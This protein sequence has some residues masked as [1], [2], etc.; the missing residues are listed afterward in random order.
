[1]VSISE[2]LD[3]FGFENMLLIAVFLISFTLINFALKKAFTRQFKEPSTAVTSVIAFAV[4]LIIVYGV[5]AMEIDL[6]SFFFDIG[7]DSA[8]LEMLVYFVLL[9]GIAFIFYKFGFAKTLMITGI[10]LIIVS[11][12]DWF[13]EADTILFAGIA[14]FVVAFI[15]FLVQRR[16]KGESIGSS[17]ASSSR[18]D[19]A[20]RERERRYRDR[21]EEERREKTLR[22]EREMEREQRF[23]AQ[24]AEDNARRAAQEAQ[25]QGTPEAQEAA[26][27]AKEKAR[28]EDKMWEDARAQ[29]AQRTRELAAKAKQQAKWDEMIRKDAE[30]RKRETEEKQR[31]YDLQIQLKKNAE[32]RAAE[33]EAY[34]EKERKEKEKLRKRKADLEW[35]IGERRQ[36]V[37]DTNAFLNN[38]NAPNRSEDNIRTAKNNLNKISNELK[39]FENEL[40]FINRRL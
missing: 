40:D 29:D 11:F 15:I 30:E 24:R 25:R 14:I 21:I 9:A 18:I 5:S 7:I 33:Y 34:A 37:A 26:R 32:I 38:Y 8:I 31:A 4:S 27:R 2:I 13:Y 35:S 20:Q 39:N 1:M 10:L 36:W 22:Q 16:K 3:A 6:G 19:W 17:G 23:R 12:T 28:A